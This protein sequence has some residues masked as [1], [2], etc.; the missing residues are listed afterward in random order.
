MMRAIGFPRG[1]VMLSVLLELVVLGIIGLFIGIVDGL[2][3]SLGFANLQNA[4]LIIPWQQ[5][6]S[7][8]SFI[9]VIAIVAGSIPAYMAS[10]IPPAEALRYVG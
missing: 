3:V 6:G 9:V 8:L 5:L 4:T 1:Q 7:Y 2:L 10:R